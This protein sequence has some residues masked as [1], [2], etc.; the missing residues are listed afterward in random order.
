VGRDYDAALELL[1]RLGVRELAV[2]RARERVLEP[3]G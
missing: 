2:F 1:D 3:I